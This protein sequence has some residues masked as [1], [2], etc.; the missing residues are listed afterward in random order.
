MLGKLSKA[1]SKR[2]TTRVFLYLSLPIAFS[3]EEQRALWM[4][5]ALK[6]GEEDEAEPRGRWFIP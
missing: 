1:F 4:R 2:Y 5:K 6:D 3:T